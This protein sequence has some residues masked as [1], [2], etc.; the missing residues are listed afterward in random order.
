MSVSKYSPQTLSALFLVAGT[1]VGGGMLALPVATSLNGFIPSS[2]VMV[3]AWLAMMLTALYLV[4]V[5]SWMK[6]EDAHI[7]S[8]SK[9]LL[10]KG[11][12]V[13]TWLLYLFICYASLVAY[14][15]GSGHLLTKA[16]TTYSSFNISKE[17][18]CVIFVLIFGPCLFFSHKALGKVN[19]VLFV[20]MIIA[21]VALISLS[22]PHIATENL[23]R[24]NWEG[25][26]LAL[27]LLLTA[28]SFQTMVPSL[29]PFLNHHAPSL[30]VAIIGG[31]ALAFIVYLIWQ[32]S[33][34]GVVPLTGEFGLT[35]ALKEGEA[36]THVLGQAVGSIYIELLASFFAFFALV[37]SFFG[38]ALGFY[39]FLSDGLNIPKKNWGNILLGALIL[40]PTLFGAC[41]LEKI[42]L[43]A[44]DASGGYGDSILNGII[45]I[46]M[47]A[48]GRYHYK[49]KQ[50]GFVAPKAKWLLI[51]ALCFYLAA[52]GIEV[53][54]HTG[55]LTAVHD[56]KEFDFE[57]VAS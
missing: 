53:L 18:G 45:P 50:N 26:W 25:S 22:V 11:G 4:E 29:H 57:R 16:V 21:Y 34:L 2:C 37:T 6:K 41:M 31:T 19:S 9:N 36:A 40:L 17:M 20:A 3:F 47:I 7:I 8:M 12:Q 15:A 27:P 28:F 54:T 13:V 33:V 30:R 52:L 51:A 5:G 1:C 32:A 10:G 42:F 35:H 44:L 43:K 39:D 48:L 23:L 49:L 55:H 38:I 56:L 24:S 46:A 14:T